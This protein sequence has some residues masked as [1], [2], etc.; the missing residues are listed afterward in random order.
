MLGHEQLK[1]EQFEIAADLFLKALAFYERLALKAPDEKYPQENLAVACNNLASVYL[2]QSK[3]QEAMEFLVKEVEARSRVTQLAPDDI[4][5]QKDLSRLLTDY[6]DLAMEA[7]D[8][9]H[10]ASFFSLD[11]AILESLMKRFPDNRWYQDRGT[12]TKIRLGRVR[13][14]QSKLAEAIELFEQAVGVREERV[15]ADGDDENAKERLIYS[16]KQLAS[17]YAKL[18]EK[19][20]T[21][22]ETTESVEQFE[23]AV[24]VRERVVQLDP[25]QDGEKQRLS[26]VLTDA[27]DAALENGQPDHALQHFRRKTEIAEA[28][29]R[30]DPENQTY[31]RSL[32]I[33]LSRMGK[34]LHQQGELDEAL[35]FVKRDLAIAETLA[36]AE[37]DNEQRQSDVSFSLKELGE[38][39]RE[40]KNLQEAL[41]WYTRKRAFEESYLKRRPDSRRLR[42]ELAD[43]LRELGE[44]NRE[45]GK[46]IESVDLLTGEI[47]LRVRLAD[48]LPTDSETQSSLMF[49]HYQ[50]GSVC[51]DLFQYQEAAQNYRAGGI[52]LGRMIENE[53]NVE[54]SKRDQQVIERL[55]GKAERNARATVS[56]DVLTELSS[57]EQTELLPVRCSAFVKQKKLN[58]AAQAAARLRTL[59]EDASPEEKKERLVLAA[60]GFAQCFNGLAHDSDQQPEEGTAERRAELS[61]LVVACLQEAI[62]AGFEDLEQLRQNRDFEPLQD[63]PEFKALTAKSDSD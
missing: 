6:G 5:L 24:S 63:V 45:L 19:Y 32:S 17:G 18:A 35:S 13:L 41:T 21:Q 44:L 40:Q 25:D 62:E 3:S 27:G 33:A 14:K 48:E 31:Q 50:L 58:E 9:D 42:G 29:V 52:V 60:R 2:R 23:L 39:C 46:L 57:D 59:S 54:K 55:A 7:G 38:I 53:Q 11:R 61:R 22:D 47:A 51:S 36:A 43:S 1:L 28:L 8:F 37:P 20:E 30:N 26:A 34:V 56:W 16:L 10:A 12:I 15:A 4:A 49:A